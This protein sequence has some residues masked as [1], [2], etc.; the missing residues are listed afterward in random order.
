MGIH[1]GGLVTGPVQ[2]AA[3]LRRFSIGHPTRGAA[4]RCPASSLHFSRHG[5]PAH[6][7]KNKVIEV[8]G[9]NGGFGNPAQM[10]EN[11]SVRMAKHSSLKPENRN[12]KTESSEFEVQSP[13]SGS[14]LRSSSVRLGP[15]QSDSIQPNPSVFLHPMAAAIY[16]PFPLPFPQSAIAH[17]LS[18]PSS[19]PQPQSNPLGPVKPV[20]APS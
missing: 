17:H 10:C 16:S 2:L 12:E 4:D 7:S 9:G 11:Q 18:A 13:K 19:H 5:L 20:V 8:M 6:N 14:P 15:S 3:D 1:E